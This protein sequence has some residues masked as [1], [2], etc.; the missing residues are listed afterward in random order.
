MDKISDRSSRKIAR[1]GVVCAMLV[2]FIHSYLAHA[3]DEPFSPFA[4]FV[5]EFISQGIARIA[6]P[7]FFA[8]SGFF[9]YRDYEFTFA[10]FRKK[11]ISRFW[12]LGVPY[13]LWALIGLAFALVTSMFARKVSFE[14]FQWSSPMWW[15]R[16]FGVIEK[17]LYLGQLWFV[18][19]LLEWLCV[20]PFVGLLVR[21]FRFAVPVIC[22][23]VMCI[24]STANPWTN[25]LMFISFGACI[26]MHGGIEKKFPNAL[27]IAFVAAG[28][29]FLAGK[30][31]F[32][33]MKCGTLPHWHLF[34]AALI[35]LPAAWLCYDLIERRFSLKWMDGFAGAAFF[36][37][38]SHNIFLSLLRSAL[39]RTAL[40]DCDLLRYLTP[41]VIAIVM[42]V[43]AWRVAGIHMPK[44]RKLLCGGR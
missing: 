13:V 26:A 12:S 2:V 19:M 22:L 5:Q 3:P 1:I 7:F 8:I 20:A 32:V 23:V 29:A 25:A 21:K 38:C 18:H 39:R 11:L 28:F 14:T 10:W 37:Y 9:L 4:S 30:A 35:G 24:P 31:A 40:W 44:C 15:V 33:A 41:P 16:T 34:A 17:P 43:L 6:V 42:A 36:I 27:S